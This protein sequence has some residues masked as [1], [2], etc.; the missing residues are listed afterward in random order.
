MIEIYYTFLDIA[1]QNQSNAVFG[2]GVEKEDS[3]VL[4]VAKTERK[5]V[6]DGFSS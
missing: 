3:S 4:R 1:S 6:H 5:F 2:F